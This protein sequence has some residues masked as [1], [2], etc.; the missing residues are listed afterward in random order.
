MKKIRALAAV[1]LCSAGFVLAAIGFAPPAAP[2]IAPNE[3]GTPARY[4]PT[5][6]GKAD[7]LDQ[8]EAVWNDRVTYPTGIFNPEWLRRA[9]A[10]DALVARSVPFGE[11]PLDLKQRGGPLVLDP[12]NFTSLGPKPERMTGCSGCFDYGITQGRVND[13]V[14]DPTTTTNGSIVAYLATD[15][16]GVWK[17]TNCCSSTTSWNVVTDDPLLS[18]IAI[19]TLTIDPNNHNTIYAGT[20]DLNYGSLLTAL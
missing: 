18:T 17:T 5:L 14:I 1:T 13:I 12:V 10:Q 8:M 15:G 4:M 7:D 16:G 3:S 11:H 6:G 20:G 19:D 9:A 2:I